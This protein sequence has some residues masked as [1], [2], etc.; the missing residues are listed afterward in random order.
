MKKIYRIAKLELSVLFYSPIA[1]IV[2]IIF[3]LQI[4][5][6]FIARLDGF[7]VSQQMG[8]QLRY[9]T[10]EVFS[11]SYGIFPEV[12]KNLYLYIPLLTMGLMSRELSSGSVK[13][14]FSSPV[15]VSQIIFG[16]FFA[17]MVYCFILVLI[18]FIFVLAGA[19]S[20]ESLEISVLISGILGLYLLV[21]AYAAIGLFMSCITSYQVVAAISTLAVLAALNFVG[22][23]GQ[24]IDTVRDITYWISISGRCDNFI[25]GLISSKNVIY[26]LIVIGLFLTLSIMKLSE[27]RQLR[28]LLVKNGRY[29]LLIVTAIFIGFLSSL[30][31]FTIY[32]DLTRNKRVTLTENSQKVVKQM[33]KPLKITTYVNVLDY[34]AWYGS[35][36]RR[37]HDM[38]A[39]EQYRRFLPNIKMEYIT[40]YDIPVNKQLIERN[41]NL[42]LKELAEKVSIASRFDFESILSPEEIKEIIDLSSEENRFV[43]ILEYGDKKAKLRMFDDMLRYPGEAEITA[44]LKRM[45]TSPPIIG[46]F[47]GHM[48]RSVDKAGDKS[49]KQFARSLPYRNSLINQGFDVADISI[50]DDIPKNLAALVLADPKINYSETDLKKIHDYINNGG[51]L[52]IAGEPGKQSI[53]NPITQ[54]LGVEFMPGNLL[55]QSKDF[56]LD[57]IV[58]KYAKTASDFGLFFNEKSKITMPGAVGLI[59]RNT[60]LFDIKPILM[61]DST[62]TWN[63]LGKLDLESGEERF[64][65]ISD[66]KISV[67]LALGLTRM[68]AGKQQTI[69]I[70]GD[71]DFM[72]NSELGRTNIRGQNSSLTM[73]MFKW[74]SNGEFPINTR[75]PGSIDNKL[76]IS[77][78]EITFFKVIFFGIFPFLIGLWGTVILIRRKRQ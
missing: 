74:F 29:I 55:Q 65:S 52:L 1:W 39:F 71:A 9:I 60:G 12:Q 69:I 17:I 20:I 16:K 11:G 61:T 45:I 40:Y 19:F 41:S 62:S 78:N 58:A 70:M 22:S 49:Y 32:F 18:L 73:G 64:D 23:I 5:I 75:R 47:N 2:L 54:K 7:D 63:R 44:A 15:A 42:S 33:D 72:S 51:N 24:N 3:I 10:F 25:S 28:S 6:T 35:P 27:G 31:I 77:R 67:P 36:S 59:Y 66:K 53:L 76:L 57:L 26:F 48:E 14:L 38:N 34:N 43:R 37:I 21:C 50:N 68:I 8:N 13:L 46:F 4:G 30:P 56:E